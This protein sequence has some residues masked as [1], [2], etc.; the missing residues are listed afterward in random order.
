M[1]IS[2]CL[3]TLNELDGCG[4]DVPRLP[5]ADFDEIYAVDGGSRDGTVSYLAS[6]GITVHQQEIPGYNGAYLTAFRRCTGEA[7]VLFHPK[8]TIDPAIL[9]QFRAHLQ[10]GCDLVIASR[11]GRGAQN[12][13]DGRLFK[14]RKWFV[15]ALGHVVS[16]LWRREG[17]RIRDVLH[18]L[19]AMRRDAFFAIEPR[20]RGVSVDLEIVVRAYRGRLRRVEIPVVE[21]ATRKGSTHFPAIPTGARLLA[22]LVSEI[23]RP[24]PPPRPL[25]R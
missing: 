2:L 14:P 23:R 19:R 21:K 10:A 3:L 9:R 17:A 16:L 13:E 1:R 8:G 20:D 24:A 7:L 11:I 12:E 4:T 15:M 18:G 5:R 22:Y 25:H 6:Q